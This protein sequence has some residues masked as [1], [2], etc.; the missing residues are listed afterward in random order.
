MVEI[1][2]DY[3]GE[4]H[5]SVVHGPSGDVIATDA[6]VDNNGRGEAFSPTDLVAAALGAC[7]CTVMG[8]VAKRKEIAMEGASVSVRKHMSA[9]TPRRIAK[10]ELD[11]SLPVAADH[12]ERPMLEAAAKGCPVHHSLHPEIEVVMNWEWKG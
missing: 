1:Q 10:I 9:D 3:E 6:P 11:I 2:I 5:C 4:L 8:I 7:M 12:P